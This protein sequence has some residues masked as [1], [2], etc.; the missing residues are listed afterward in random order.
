MVPSSISNDGLF[1]YENHILIIGYPHDELE[2]P[3]NGKSCRFGVGL[4]PGGKSW[5]SGEVDKKMKQ[6]QLPDA[7]RTVLE[8][9]P[10]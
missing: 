1:P 7:N 3:I 5:N 9:L 6:Q 2:P 8:Y 10:T 4:D